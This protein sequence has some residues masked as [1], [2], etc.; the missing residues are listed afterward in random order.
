MLLWIGSRARLEPLRPEHCVPTRVAVG[1]VSV[2]AAW[3]T[4]TIGKTLPAFVLGQLPPSLVLLPEPEYQRRLAGL[5]TMT[6]SVVACGNRLITE[7]SAK[8]T[9][10][11]PPTLL[12]P[13][14]IVLVTGSIQLPF[15]EQPLIA[16]VV[17][18]SPVPAVPAVGSKTSTP[19]LGMVRY[20]SPSTG[21]KRGCSAL[22]G[23]GIDAVTVLAFAPVRS[24]PV[25]KNGA[26]VLPIYTR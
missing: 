9:S 10:A 14:S 2:P 5:K 12:Q 23:S 1:A 8:L 26:V 21:L 4:P 18:R 25:K 19:T 11:W 16:Y 6:S 22:P 3:N 7:P 15:P 17:I 13:T 24:M 20:M